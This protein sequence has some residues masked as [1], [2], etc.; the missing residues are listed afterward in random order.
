MGSPGLLLT[1]ETR[2]A[3]NRGSPPCSFSQ[4]SLAPC[5]LWQ[6]MNLFHEVMWPG[7]PCPDTGR[8]LELFLITQISSRTVEQILG[9]FTFWDSKNENDMCSSLP[10]HCYQ[11]VEQHIPIT[12]TAVS[13]TLAPLFLL[14]AKD[15]FPFHWGISFPFHCPLLWQRYVCN[16]SQS[17]HYFTCH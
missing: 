9:D 6:H 10:C 8:L 5:L 1:M 15:N 16:N 11:V 13:L 12:Y 7:H 17:L 4:M 3:T 2:H 14:F